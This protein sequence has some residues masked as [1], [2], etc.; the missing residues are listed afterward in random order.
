MT[1]AEFSLS[2]QNCQRHDA[3][4]DLAGKRPPREFWRNLS[5][6][7]TFRVRFIEAIYEAAR[8]QTF[9]EFLDN[10]EEIE[11]NTSQ[12]DFS[13]LAARTAR[14][15]QNAYRDL[16]HEMASAGRGRRP[17]IETAILTEKTI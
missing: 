2:Q 6:Q 5:E 10:L 15:E 7:T 3:Q 11:V 14:G 8:D 9:N 17:L 13:A 12:T 1:R 16:I 4:I